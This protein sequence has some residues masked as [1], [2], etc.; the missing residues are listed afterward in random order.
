MVAI[1]IFRRDFRVRDNTSLI[2]A[3]KDGHKILPI[4]I[5][6]PEQILKENNEYF[7]NNAVQFLCESLIDLN[8]QLK[9]YGSRLHIFFGDNIDILKY[10][11]TKYKFDAVYYN[12]DHSVYAVNRDNEISKWCKSNDIIDKSCE[13]YTLI[14]I[15]E[16]LVNDERPYLI[17]A[18]FYKRV[19]KEIPIRKVD[20][21]KFKET[22]FVSHEFSKEVGISNINK[23]YDENPNIAIK[24]G[25]TD[26]LK[27]LRN[28]A[29]LEKYK[30]ERDYPALQKTSMMSP[31]LRFGTVSIREMYWKIESLFGKYHDLIRELVFRD[32]YY[33]IY[34]FKP[35]LQRGTALYNEFDKAIPWSY[36]KGLFEKWTNG[37]TGY[38]LVDAGM[39]ELNATGHQH[40]RLRMLCG[41]VLTKYFLIDW[42]WGL[43]YYY[44]HL[45]DADV[46]SNTAGW[47][48]VSSTGPDGVPY[49]R[50]PFNP[51]T[52]SKK[53]DKDA[54]YIKKWV[55]E[56][57]DVDAKDVHKWYDNTIRNKYDVDYPEPVI[58]HKYASTRAMKVFKE[59]YPKKNMNGGDNKEENEEDCSCNYSF[60]G[61]NGPVNFFKC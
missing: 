15:N 57:K 11:N 58:D 35:K 46:F 5:F 39:R 9:K 34:A 14:P 2:K 45:V 52:Q 31:H 49:F 38:P 54:I 3:I 13:D 23:Y 16:G 36:D 7:S 33:K 24:G 17:L 21:L 27:K 19:L 47:G 43:K 53:F 25:R 26:A 20:K 10:I 18:Q 37:K 41:S 61:C 56:L 51:Y 32:F 28:I 50:A 6:T 30:E 12:K 1:F 44:K 60:I 42:R 4:F 48:F 22:F 8:E 29:N 40:N 55:P 59:A